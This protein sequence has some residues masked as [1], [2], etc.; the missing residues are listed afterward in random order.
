MDTH[1][2]NRLAIFGVGLRRKR[3][4]QNKERDVPMQNRNFTGIPACPGSVQE[5]GL[6]KTSTCSED[7]SNAAQYIEKVKII[8][9]IF[10][11]IV[12]AQIARNNKKTCSRPIC[13]LPFR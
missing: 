2:N 10:I 6:V 11:P 1:G 5:K 8:M 4:D 7:V 12:I 9:N 3:I 13:H